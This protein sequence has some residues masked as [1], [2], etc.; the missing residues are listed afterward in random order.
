[1]IEMSIEKLMNF[2]GSS[3]KEVYSPSEDVV[4]RINDI[5]EKI[6]VSQTQL[7]MLSYV[8]TGQKNAES[9]FFNSTEIFLNDNAKKT[10]AFA[11]GEI[12][13]ARDVNIAY[14]NISYVGVIAEVDGQK[15]IIAQSVQGM[16]PEI[17]VDDYRV[18][19]KQLSRGM[20]LNNLYFE[21]YAPVKKKQYDFAA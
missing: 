11:V 9:Y 7:D 15:K 20:G 17:R 12:F 4:E 3:K 1:V 13:I 21:S 5:K 14:G 10:N 8:Y 2:F 16:D 6:Y 18:A 19:K